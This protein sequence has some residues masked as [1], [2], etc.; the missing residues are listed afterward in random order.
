MRQTE[1]GFSGFPAEGLRFLKSLKRNNRRDWFQPRKEIYESALKRP[2]TELVEAINADLA[3]VAPGYVTETKKAIFRIYRDTRFSHD[4]TPYKTHIAA[5]FG[6]RGAPGHR[7]GMLYFHVSPVE[8][9]IAGGIYHPEPEELRQLRVHLSDNHLE[10]RRI[11]ANKRL[12]SV[13]GQLRGEETSRLPKGFAPDHPA[14]DFLRKKDLILD[15]TLPQERAL[16]PELLREITSRFRLMLPFV[17]FL[18]R[19]LKTAPAKLDP[20]L[21]F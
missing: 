20:R 11:L 10:L 19:P 21:F 12:R 5:V 9:E 1:G 18:N 6:K 7:G 16:G 8:V 2:M 17:E 3:K 13:L 4:K 15:V 14:Q